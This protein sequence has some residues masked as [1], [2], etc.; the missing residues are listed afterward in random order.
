MNWSENLEY[1]NYSDWR[2]PN[3]KELHSI[4]SYTRC[5]DVT[6]SAAIDPIFEVTAIKNEG[7]QKDYPYYWISTTHVGFSRAVADDLVHRA[8]VATAQGLRQ[9]LVRFGTRPVFD[10]QQEKASSRNYLPQNNLS[11]GQEWI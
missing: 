2:L 3:A 8:R 4:V 9:K 1:G 10:H 6:N 11:N 7:G 5:P